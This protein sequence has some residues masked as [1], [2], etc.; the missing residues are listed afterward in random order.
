LTLSSNEA[1]LAYIYCVFPMIILTR[2]W[3]VGSS[4]FLSLYYLHS[5]CLF[6]LQKFV[7][8]GTSSKRQNKALQ[9]D[10][11]ED[12][13]MKS[14]SEENIDEDSDEAADKQEGDYGSG[15]EKA[16][17]KLSE[18]KESSGKKK[19]NTGSGHKSGPPSKIIKNLVKKVSSKIHEEKE[20]PNDSA[21]VFSRKKK[22]TA[23][24]EI[25]EKKS[26][27]KAVT[28]ISISKCPLFVGV[29]KFP[30][31]FT[32]THCGS[33]FLEI[34]LVSYSGGYFC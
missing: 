23:E 10:T 21:K 27:G 34:I 13:S 14:D 30:V 6:L 31:Q 19:S 7:D 26:S 32:F 1:F 17:K 24:K 5:H 16:G 20:S 12:E 22:P 11:D 9:Y 25:K 3:S 28:L 8:D 2:S 33:S 4:F 18:V 29:W 15:K